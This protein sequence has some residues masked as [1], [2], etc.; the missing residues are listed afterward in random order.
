LAI[1]AHS[2]NVIVDQ[3][4]SRQIFD[5]VQYTHL[6]GLG[7]LDPGNLLTIIGPSK[8]ESLSGFRLGAAFGS[9]QMIDRMEKLQA[10]V[11]LRAAGDCQAVLANWF[12]EPKGWMQQRIAAH[13]AIRDDIHA[14][15]TAAG[16]RQHNGMLVQ[17]SDRHRH[18]FPGLSGD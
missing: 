16:T 3:L 4:Y 9:S 10:I 13:Q 1:S 6:C 11:S 14:A 15:F 8:T 7:T 17:K 18:G 12:A 2:V 5:G